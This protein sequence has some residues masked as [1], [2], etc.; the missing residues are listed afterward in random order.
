[1]KKHLQPI[2]GML[3]VIV[4]KGKEH[5]T[6]EKEILDFIDR[7]AVPDRFHCL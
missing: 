5:E 6:Y 7:G 4:R 1:M 2:K 3:G